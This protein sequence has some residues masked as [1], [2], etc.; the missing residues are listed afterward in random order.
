MTNQQNQN[1]EKQQ[2]KSVNT[3][4]VFERN[5]TDNALGYG[6]TDPNARALNNMTNKTN[7]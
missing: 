1:N 5:N 3:Q 4:S 6:D 7:Q 2:K